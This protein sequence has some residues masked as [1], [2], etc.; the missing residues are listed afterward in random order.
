MNKSII[1]VA[2]LSG[3]SKSTVSRVLT[4][5]SVSEK[6]RKAVYR[7]MEELKFT[8]NQMAR[9]LRG[10]RTRVAG[11][12]ITMKD[13]LLSTYIAARIAGINSVLSEAG[14]SLLFINCREEEEGW[15]EPFRFLEQNLVDGLIFLGEFENEVWRQKMSEY[16]PVI[17]TGERYQKDTGFR[18]YMGNYYFSQELYTCLMENGHHRILT[19]YSNSMGDQ[20]KKIRRNALEEVCGRFRVPYEE[21]S[22]FSIEELKTD[23]FETL[24]LIYRKF[25]DENYTAVFTHSVELANQ[26]INYFSLKGLQLLED[27]SIVA[28]ERGGLEGKKD[29]VITAVCLPD[30]EYGVKCASLLMQVL[31]D[32]TL[33]YGDVTIP[34]HLEIRHSVKDITQK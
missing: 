7:A 28:I 11:V 17:Y 24:E 21:D 34:Y 1:D 16:R 19:V 25:S 32:E 33:T 22:F 15:V 14:Y 20:I 8:P 23:A 26:V 27:Y 29:S 9:G 18:V 10:G 13:A 30:Y 5:G 2:K 6:S 4:G 12:V 31:N 3:V